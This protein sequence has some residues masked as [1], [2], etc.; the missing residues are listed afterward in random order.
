MG[1]M[2]RQ[3][4]AETPVLPRPTAAPRHPGR[5]KKSRHLLERRRLSKIWQECAAA[6]WAGVVAGASAGVVVAGS[7]VVAAGA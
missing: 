2:Q 6:Y 3:A 7:V 4:V 1:I 5:P